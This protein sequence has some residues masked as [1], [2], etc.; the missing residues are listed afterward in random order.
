VQVFGEDEAGEL[1]EIFSSSRPRNIIAKTLDDIASGEL[2]VV[3]DRE[4][5]PSDAHDY[6]ESRR[7][8]GRVVRIV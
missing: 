3:I 5:P 6:V 8:L 1:I 2:R 4:F 7:A